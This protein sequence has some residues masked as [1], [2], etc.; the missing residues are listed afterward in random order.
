MHLFNAFIHQRAL[1][2]FHVLAVVN[3]AARSKGCRW[4]FVCFCFLWINTHNRIAWLYVTSGFNFLNLL[5]TVVL[6]GCTRELIL[7]LPSSPCSRCPEGHGGGAGETVQCSRDLFALSWKSLVRIRAVT[8][9]RTGT[10]QWIEILLTPQCRERPAAGSV[11]SIVGASWGPGRERG[12]RHQAGVNEGNPSASLPSWDSRLEVRS[13]V[14]AS[15]FHAEV[16]VNACPTRWVFVNAQLSKRSSYSLTQASTSDRISPKWTEFS[17]HREQI[18]QRR[19]RVCVCVCVCVHPS[20]CTQAH[21]L[22]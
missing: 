1:G 9:K 20:P 3:D 12:C 17:D 22:C 21:M 15:A 10:S 11:H 2:C 4:V 5:H 8:M 6:K 14:L 7:F 16:S 13:T 19:S 18:V